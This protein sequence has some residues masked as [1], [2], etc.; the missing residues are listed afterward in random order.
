MIGAGE[1]QEEQVR[2]SRSRR[3]EAGAEEEQEWSSKSRIGAGEEQVR[4]RKKE[5]DQEI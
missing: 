3:G 1:E 2:C 5:A 4:S